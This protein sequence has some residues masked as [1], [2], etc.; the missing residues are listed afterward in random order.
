[1]LGG[2]GSLEGAG[3]LLACCGG[4]VS[5]VGDCVAAAVAVAVLLRRHYLRKKRVPAQERQT[6]K[7]QDGGKRLDDHAGKHMKRSRETCINFEKLLE[8]P[9]KQKKLFSTACRLLTFIEKV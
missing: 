8:C 6:K 2:V 5:G 3:S 4:A 9:G 7:I 1:M